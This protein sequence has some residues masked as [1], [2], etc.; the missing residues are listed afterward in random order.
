MRAAESFRPNEYRSIIATDRICAIGLAMPMPAIS[1]AD[2]PL[3]RDHLLVPGLHL[4]L[5]AEQAGDGEAPDVGVEDPD[6][7]APA[8]HGHGE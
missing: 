2:P 1:G 7:Q 5:H 3:E 6:G 8:G 4:T